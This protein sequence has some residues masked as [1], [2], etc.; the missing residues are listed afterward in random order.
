M[1]IEKID[2]GLDVV[3]SILSKT[4]TIIKKHWAILLFLLFCAF[5]YWAWNLPDEP[6]NEFVEPKTEQNESGNI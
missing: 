3:D 1:A 2:K 6:I 5:I 4:K